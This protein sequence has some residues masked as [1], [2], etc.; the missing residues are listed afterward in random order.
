M[1]IIDELKES[2]ETLILA[3]HNADI[4]AVGASIGLYEYLDG[5]VDLA[6]PDTVSKGAKDL[7]KGY[8]FIKNPPLLNPESI[9]IHN[10][11]ININNSG[12]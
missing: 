8:S 7:S 11:S 5:K 3:H 12:G 10:S 9:K 4:D 1:K 6:V 2:E